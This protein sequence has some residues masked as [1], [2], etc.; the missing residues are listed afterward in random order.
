MLSDASRLVWHERLALRDEDCVV[1]NKETGC[2]LTLNESAFTILLHYESGFSVREVTE[3]IQHIFPLCASEARAWV[4]E[5]SEYL[6]SMNM[7]RLVDAP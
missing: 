7:I 6:C 4:L 5:F 1:F 2:V 3:S